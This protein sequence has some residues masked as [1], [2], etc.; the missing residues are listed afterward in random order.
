MNEKL[1]E[2]FRKYLSCREILSSVFKLSNENMVSVCSAVMCSKD[3][4]ADAETIENCAK[5]LR[6]NTGIL[7][8][9]RAGVEIPVITM[10]ASSKNPEEKIESAKAIHKE[11]K[12]YHSDSEYLAYSSMI[13]TDM[14]SLER[15]A[16]IGERS[17][18]IY[19]MM[20]KE[21]RFLTG[22]EDTVFAILL[23]FSEKSDEALIAETEECY[24]ILKERP[25][26]SNAV[27][28]V[29]H[30]FALA[31]GSAKEKCDRFTSLFEALADAGYKYSKQ[32]ELAALAALS[33]SAADISEL[34]AEIITV[35]DELAKQKGYKGVFGMSKQ[36]T[37]MHAVMIVSNYRMDTINVDNAAV[38]SVVTTIAAQ[39]AAICAI[40]A[41]N[42]AAIA[43]N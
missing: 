15:A 35:S 32:Y 13:L 7:S 33:L 41:I 18:R 14:I 19:K 23:A 26:T 12:N 9:F 39:Q 22:I 21:H 5:V 1:M 8:G 2:E 31:D 17:K 43:A 6:K 11:L 42:A 20:K 4:S 25:F 24:S 16:E 38:M 34:A 28:S 37:L 36:T 10:L 3:A 30:I 29:S 40:I 27:Q